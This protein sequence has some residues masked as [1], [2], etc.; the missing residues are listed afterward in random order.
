VKIAFFRGAS[1]DPVPPI[2]SKQENVRY[3]HIHENDEL[4]EAQLRSWIEQAS[5]L[6]GEKI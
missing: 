2:A 1:L 5:K 6:P 3:V 4:D